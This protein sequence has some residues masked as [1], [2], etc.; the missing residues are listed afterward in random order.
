MYCCLFDIDQIL[1]FVSCKSNSN[2]ELI[3]LD[4]F[5]LYRS[6]NKKNLLHKSED[7]TDAIIRKLLTVYFTFFVINMAISTP[8]NHM[9]TGV[10]QI[11]GDC[12]IFDTDLAGHKRQ[13]LLHYHLKE[14]IVA[15]FTFSDRFTFVKR[16]SKRISISNVR[17]SQN[18]NLKN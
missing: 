3:H 16:S 15:L 5:F 6:K 4:K 12:D 1:A 11:V 8:E 9:S 17:I 10:H 18:S 7:D 14:E 13:V 2:C